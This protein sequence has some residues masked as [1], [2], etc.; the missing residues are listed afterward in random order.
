M[1]VN[2]LVT[3]IAAATL[4]AV[5]GCS[6]SDEQ[7]AQD[8]AAAS[9]RITID[10]A[11]GDAQ[12]DDSDPNTADPSKQTVARLRE[13]RDLAKDSARDAAA[14]AQLDS[15]WN[16]LSEATQDVYAVKERVLQ[17]RQSTANEFEFWEVM[18]DQDIRRH[19]NG[20]ALRRT[21]CAALA[22]LL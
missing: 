8:F 1:R 11:S 20:L 15:S 5:A 9:C 6:E 14:A 13:Q 19:N 21:E 3:T 18:T 12:F 17:V 10:D 7:R 22:S 2:L 16:R 4:L